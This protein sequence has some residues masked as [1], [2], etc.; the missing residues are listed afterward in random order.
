MKP[1]SQ[2]E[3]EEQANLW[4]AIR[5]YLHNCE[6]VAGANGI[7]YKEY[8]ILLL[9]KKADYFS[10]AQVIENL[11]C[12]KKTAVRLCAQLEEKEL[13]T[14]FRLIK[15]GAR[16]FYRLTGKGRAALTAVFLQ[17]VKEVKQIQQKID[18]LFNI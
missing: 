3:Y 11:S 17:E 1:V 15:I 8:Q 4:F 13:I 18:L 6:K 16:R 14:S 12:N 9:L 5:Q 7:S 2:Q 10:L